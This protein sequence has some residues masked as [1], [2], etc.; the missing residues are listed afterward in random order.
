MCERE[1]DQILF[2][3][4]HMG[5]EEE[6]SST[7]V[8]T[9]ISGDTHSPEITHTPETFIQWPAGVETFR[10]GISTVIGRSRKLIWTLKGAG[11]RE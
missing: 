5:K 7:L 2:F 11:E 4:L 8:H 9:D 3:Y 1:S 10:S 6:R